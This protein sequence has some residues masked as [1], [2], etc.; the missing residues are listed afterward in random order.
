MFASEAV[1]D[2]FF[3]MQRVQDNLSTRTW[4][5]DCFILFLIKDRVY[6][7]Y[8]DFIFPSVP[9]STPPRSSQ[10]PHSR[11]CTPSLALLLEDKQVPLKRIVVK[12]DETKPNLSRTKQM[13]R[14][15]AKEKSKEQTQKS[16]KDAK[17]EPSYLIKRPAR[18]SHPQKLS[19]AV[20][21]NKHRA[22]QRDNMQ[23]A[24]ETLRSQS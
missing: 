24:R 7:K 15:T 17:S 3:H 4:Y 21:G 1:L 19:P 13:D 2:L 14:K 10:T 12:Q 8:S 6:T 23:K 16:R 5:A 22:P 9:P 11:K 18:V 20:S